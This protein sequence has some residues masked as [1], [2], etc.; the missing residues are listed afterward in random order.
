MTIKNNRPVVVGIFVLLGL[1]ILVVTVFTLGGQ[2]K[3]F[4]KSFTINA[5]FND[6]GG[7][8]KGS[9]IWFSGVKIGT[10]K[11]ISFYNS[12]QVLVSMSIEQ[13]AESHIHKD[14]MA[15]IGSDGLIGNKIIVIYGGDSTKPQVEKNDFLIVEKSTSTDDMLATLQVTNKNLLAITTD[16]KSIS[17]KIDT[18]KGTLAS[19]INDGTVAKKISSSVDNLQVTMANF[20]TASANSKRVLIN[21]EAF[22]QKLNT[23]GNSINDIA[24]DTVFYNSIKNT[25]S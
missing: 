25:L 13:E 19:L 8:L 24:S 12:S 16:F 18:G 2:K 21:L 11:K 15:K 23:P 9:N 3:T 10:V 22:S 20:N 17:R 4:V 5:V 1:A 14:A 7:L 6:V